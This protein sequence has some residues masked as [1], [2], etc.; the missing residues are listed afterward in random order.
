MPRKK[1]THSSEDEYIPNSSKKK[2]VI[3]QKKNPAQKPKPKSPKKVPLA[4]SSD[5]LKKIFSSSNLLSE[6][7]LTGLIV[8]FVFFTILSDDVDNVV[9]SIFDE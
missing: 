5:R 8:C 1:E 3:S 2:K 4:K 6:V 7:V 9:S